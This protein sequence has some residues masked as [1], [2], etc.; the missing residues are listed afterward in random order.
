YT[1]DGVNRVA[2]ACEERFRRNG[3]SVERVSHAPEEGDGP[4][5]GD[6]LIGRTG[7]AESGP[8]VLMIGHT[9]T[10]FSDGTVGERPFHVEG[11]RA[12]GPGVCD[13]KSGVLA[14]LFAAEL[15]RANGGF[16]G[17]IV[18]VCNPDEE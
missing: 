15:L 14:G 2:D 3:W 10:V 11:D 7:D 18:Y 12:F 4:R 16:L 6:L 13:M 1:R 8:T 9:D 17:R 5:L